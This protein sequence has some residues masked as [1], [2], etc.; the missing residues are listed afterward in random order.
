MLDRL[1][2]EH[3]APTLAGLKTANLLRCNAGAAL[4]KQVARWDA[5]LGTKGVHVEVLREQDGSALV[6]VYRE[7]QL[8]ADLAQEDVRAFLR[9][10]GYCGGVE[11]CLARLRE[12]LGQAAFPHEVGVFLGYPLGDV[13]GFMQ[14]GGKNAKCT[15][16]WKVYCDQCA[17]QRQFA[18]LKKCKEVYVRQ[19]QKGT[20]VM[21]L[22]VGV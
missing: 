5:L 7:K 1:L 13:I 10:F 8:K 14:H 12:R 11:L 20:S 3:C 4:R 18:R 19:F 21:K 2:I 9:H 6:Y 22:T 16:C 17:A 15:G